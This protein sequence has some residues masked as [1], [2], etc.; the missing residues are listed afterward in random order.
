MYSSHSWVQCSFH[1]HLLSVLVMAK[2][3]CKYQLLDLNLK[4]EV[5]KE[6]I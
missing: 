5:L 1:R 6:Q 2:L 4:V 3:L